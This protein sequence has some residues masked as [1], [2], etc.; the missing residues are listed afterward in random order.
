MLG[1]AATKDKVYL[2]AELPS[3]V[4]VTWSCCCGAATCQ[5]LDFYRDLPAASVVSTTTYRCYNTSTDG[6]LHET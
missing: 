1:A 6:T 4:I 5:I 3:K 2:P